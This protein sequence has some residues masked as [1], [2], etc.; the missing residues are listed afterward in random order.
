M[1][2]FIKS[3][4]NNIILAKSEKDE[5]LIVFGTGIGFKKKQGDLIDPSMVTKIFK[6][7]KNVHASK[8]L[9]QISPKLL[10]VTE[11]IVR[12]GEEKLQKNL[13][14]SILFALADHLQFAIDRD[15]D[16][17][18]DN[19]LQWEVPYLYYEEYEVGKMV[20]KIIE[21]DLEYSLPKNE[22]AFIA[23]HFVNAQIDSN[24][25]EDTIQITKL[26]KNVVKIIQRLFDINL[27]KTTISYSRFIT[28]LRYFIAR[29]KMNKRVDTQMDE[30]LKEIIQERYIKSYA[31]GLI[32]KDMVEKEFNWQVT[33]DE[34]AYLVIH[35]QRIVQENK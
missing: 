5:E 35:I 29:Q 13:N 16:I 23:L 10:A 25:I 2:T 8:F 27:D 1:L 31:C 32:I 11:K 15:N 12:L 18:K 28:H 6:P 19:P 7:E 20:L 14:Q 21:E 33:N 22:A 4:N 9:E 24:S 34:I 17:N 26:I 3:L 30:T